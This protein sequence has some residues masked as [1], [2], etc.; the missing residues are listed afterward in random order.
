MDRHVDEFVFHLRSQRGLSPNTIAAY[1]RT[2]SRLAGFLKTDRPE[3]VTRDDVERFVRKAQSNGLAARS[4]AQ[5]VVAIR[6]FFR[7]AIEAGWIA[8]NPTGDVEIPRY[9][10]RLPLVLSATETG[11]VLEAPDEATPVGLRDRA[12]LELLYGS[13]LR[14][15]EALGLDL[16]Q[17]NLVQNFVIARGKGRKERIVPI[18]DPCREAVARWLRDGRPRMLTAAKRVAIRG[19]RDP[20]FVTARGTVLTRQGLFRNLRKYGIEAGVRWLISPHKLRHSFA[21]DLVEGG[22]DLRVVQEMLGHAD[23]A[24]TE[25]YTHVSRKHLKDVYRRAH[26]RA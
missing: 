22:A 20:L 14:V 23:I 26:P 4:L 15:S 11:A 5:M 8:E 19:R 12:I 1:S 25:I 17:I 21:T 10:K 13:G 2:L 24:T 7:Y 3:S 6:Q 18:S 9:R 16:A